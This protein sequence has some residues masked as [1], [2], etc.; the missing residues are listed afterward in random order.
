MSFSS[1]PFDEAITVNLYFYLSTVYSQARMIFVKYAASCIICHYKSWL[2]S[3][4]RERGFFFALPNRYIQ[5]VTAQ[6]HG[7]AGWNGLTNGMIFFPHSIC[8]LFMY[9]WLMVC[10][11][12]LL[13]CYLLNI[14]CKDH[15]EG[16]SHM[17]KTNK[18]YIDRGDLGKMGHIMYPEYCGTVCMWPY[19][20]FRNRLWH[21]FFIVRDSFNWKG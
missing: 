13:T 4:C 11:F 19:T 17:S 5:M 9:I 18:Q 15:V 6:Q 14:M 2:K 21:F 7:S 20:V 16:G 10:L 1:K 3:R 8:L 12:W